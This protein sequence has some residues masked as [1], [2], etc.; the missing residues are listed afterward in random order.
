MKWIFTTLF[1][2]LSLGASATTVYQQS[3]LPDGYKVCLIGDTGT[4]SRSQIMVAQALESEGCHQV[5][6]LGDVIYS[7]GLKNAKDKKFF[8]HFYNPYKGLLEGQN[9]PF[10]LVMG[11]HDYQKN[12]R[13][14]IEI[15]SNY[16]NIIFPSLYYFESYG[17]VCFLSLDSNTDYSEQR[18][19]VD[20]VVLKDAG[21]CKLSIA[22]AHHPLYSVGSHGDAS[23]SL[24]GFLQGSVEGRVDSYFSGHDHNLSYEGQNKGTHFFVSGAGAK[25]RPLDRSP[26]RGGYAISDYGYIAMTIRRDNGRV[27][28]S[29]DFR[30]VK[31]ATQ[32]E[33]TY[34]GQFAGQGLR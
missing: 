5:R 15:A 25:L 8:S 32:V 21:T 26:R 24:K 13:A 27:S 6:V 29:Y 10:F 14:W 23:W 16:S 20:Q 2:A 7:S 31:S 19:F 33:S 30:V 4:A 9:I 12:P 1:M 22:L 11:N 18:E 34:S 28:A 3:Y 17:D